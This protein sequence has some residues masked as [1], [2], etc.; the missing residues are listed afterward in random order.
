MI[1]VSCPGSTS[2]RALKPFLTKESWYSPGGQVADGKTFTPWLVAHQPAVFVGVD[3][4]CV[5]GGHTRPGQ[6]FD[7]DVGHRHGFA[8]RVEDATGDGAAQLAILAWQRLQPGSG[9]AT[10]KY[11][12]SP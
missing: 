10:E 2:T 7:D 9:F 11:S 4:E 12:F 5:L 6:A 8:S 3:I 1:R